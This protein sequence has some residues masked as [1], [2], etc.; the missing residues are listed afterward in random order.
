MDIFNYIESFQK[1]KFLKRNGWT[2]RGLNSDTIAGHVLDAISVG[3]FIS[4]LEKANI[5]KVME[6]LMIHDSLMAYME[7]VTP[8]SGK[9]DMKKDYEKEAFNVFI[10]TVGDFK[11]RF[12]QLF[13]EFESKQTPESII[14]KESDKI[15]TLLQGDK[16]E[17]EENK[18]VLSEFLITYR[19]VFKTKTSKDI[20][21]Q[22]V[23][24]HEERTF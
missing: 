21:E 6:M 19:N 23:K 24:R 13:N 22:I 15:A 2:E 8:Q 14:A 4:V 1:I 3:Y 17:I 11:E 5:H 7:D 12:I 9:Y 16:Y 10:N 20:F 18:D